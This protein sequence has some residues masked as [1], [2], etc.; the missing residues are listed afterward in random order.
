[1][2]RLKFAFFLPL[3]LI[4][5]GCG[6]KSSGPA[7]AAVKG[8]VTL[9]GAPLASG[10]IV[11]EEATPGMPAAELDI[12]DGAYSG[13]VLVGSKT[14]RI[15]SYKDKDA[16]LA[17][18]PKSAPKNAGTT[19]MTAQVNTLPAKY[20]TASKETREVKV[21]GPNEFDFTVTSK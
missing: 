8:K 7:I 19:S 17:G 4:L 18:S 21:G 14:V 11:F 16:T 2:Q 5:L 3:L 9:D 20:N 15:S 6:G 1:M 12:I 13:E 10:K